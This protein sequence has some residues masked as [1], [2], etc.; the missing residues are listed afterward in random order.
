[1]AQL[2][3]TATL[4]VLTLLAPPPPPLSPG[5][6][7]PPAGEMEARA[8]PE[9][10]QGVPPFL[11]RLR[12]RAALYRRAVLEFTC[13]E[14][15]LEEDVRP[16]SGDLHWRQE[17]TYRYLLQPSSSQSIVS[18]YRRILSRNGVP[19]RE[20]PAVVR[21]HAPPP[22]L[23]AA[24]LDADY[25]SLFSFE[26]LGTEKRGITDTVIIGFEGLLAFKEGLR[27]AEWSGRVWIDRDL[28]NPVH[29]EAEPARQDAAL[30]ILVDK[31]RRAFRL[32]GIP[33]RARPRAYALS[34]DFLVTHATGLSFPSQSTWRRLVLN[35]QG[36]RATERMVQRRFVDYGL[37]DI[38][39]DEIIQSL[40]D[41]LDSEDTLPP[42]PGP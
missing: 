14:T 15:L 39:T 7:P 9:A 20:A 8:A 31:Y 4:L 1:M 18:E 42:D 37:F 11:R 36:E 19:V 3:T 22:Y 16:W 17:A 40:R 34:V 35:G 33:L 25:A 38:E 23:W 5:P 32:A 21:T 12:R 2:G 6:A 29:L 10:A 26:I 27:L 30:A 24:L 41:L 13:T 28:L